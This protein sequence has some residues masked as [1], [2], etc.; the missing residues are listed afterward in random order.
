[1]KYRE[2]RRNLRIL[3]VE[4]DHESAATFRDKLRELGYSV[5]LSRPQNLDT[6]RYYAA[7]CVVAHATIGF[8]RDPSK[9][10]RLRKQFPEI[11]LIV[12]PL[13]H[14]NGTRTAPFKDQQDT[15]FYTNDFS[16]EDLEKTIYEE[17][18]RRKANI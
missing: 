4:K 13:G 14:V 18:N 8:K 10:A 16:F 3:V 2:D 9:L 11:P 6:V 15:I 1:M 5:D 17:S 12:A 7:D